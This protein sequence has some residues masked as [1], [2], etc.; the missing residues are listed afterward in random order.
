ML[1]MQDG[2]LLLCDRSLSSE[3]CEQGP[4]ALCDCDV[5]TYVAT[6][7]H[8]FDFIIGDENDCDNTFTTMLTQQPAPTDEGWYIG[9]G[10]PQCCFWDNRIE[11]GGPNPCTGSCGLGY[12]HMVSP[13]PNGPATIRSAFNPPLVPGVYFMT[14][15]ASLGVTGFCP[16]SQSVPE[17]SGFAFGAFCDDS[18]G[19]SPHFAALT[20]ISLVQQ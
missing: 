14:L 16:N 19:Q 5:A 8:V 7:R 1:A 4:P 15:A 13:F 20:V 12:V 18:P 10:P 2:A 3:C 17:V 6:L 11:T 9:C